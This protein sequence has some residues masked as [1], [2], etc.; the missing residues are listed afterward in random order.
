MTAAPAGTN[1]TPG[2]DAFRFNAAF[3]R[4]IGWLTDWEQQALRNKRVA[5]AG[6]GGVGGFHLLT[7]AR[8]GIGAFNIADLDHFEIANFNRQIGATMD[9]LGRPKA[10]TLGEMA[11]AIN[12]EL[13]IKRFDTGIDV[14]N[15]DAFLDGVDLFVDGFDFFVLDIRRKVFARC[16]E[17]GIPALTAAPIG[18][19]VGFLAFTKDGMTFEDYFRLEGQ[20][21]LRQYV[22]FFLGVAPSGIHLSYLADPSRLDIKGKKG[23]STVVGCELCAAVTAA[24]A[25]KLLI[26][27][28]EVK[29]A[30]YHHH[31]DAYLG[32]TV[33]TCLPQGNAT[34]E[35]L[36]K[37][38]K[39]ELLFRGMPESPERKY[40][41]SVIEEI[42]DCARWAPSGDNAQPWRF[43]ITGE[44]TL[45]VHIANE[46]G[47]NV[48]EYRDGE[49]TIIS[50]GIL[51]ETLRIAA[52]GFQRRMDWRYR[53]RDGS[54]YRIEARF[55]P[56]NTIEPDP[57]GGYLS[58]RS[59]NR[60]PYHLR[61]LR[62]TDKQALEAALGNRLTIDWHESAGARWRIARLVGKATDIRLRIPEAFAVHQ[63]I[64]DWNGNLSPTGIPAGAIG[65]DD[66]TLRIMKWAMQAWSRTKRLNRFA[67]T[68][69]AVLQ[70]DYLPGLCSA[71]YFTIRMN[72]KEA[73]PDERVQA[74]LET[75]QAIQRF[76]LTATKLGLAMQPCLATLAFAHY[77]RSGT[78]FTRE[79]GPLRAAGK[80]AAS[81]DNILAGN[82]EFVFM[83]RLG[84]PR[85]RK[86][87]CRSTR[88]SFD[89][90]IRAS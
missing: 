53:G 50:A 47:G 51:L 73:S 28:G 39:A 21:Q 40:P 23:P 52:S 75:G 49:P 37:L 82:G 89:Q 44:D 59:V 76:W 25:V 33:V 46:S 13:R 60:W 11:L 86:K 45:I 3:D 83:G 77:G 7:L 58:L 61:P 29:P 87:L 24:A 1:T 35:Q 90:L 78:P 42:I 19:G 41:S 36:K 84:W 9:T 26:G 6:M 54:I 31:F 43:Q 65:L 69:G 72:A 81:V 64:I 14:Q 74:L 66:M 55:S 2:D 15:M 16:A 62:K 27:R 20:S 18:M 4:N 10:E 17:L 79:A 56:D 30:P 88:R 80:L 32:Q 8:L 63:R 71:A 22:N 38:E 34:P 5:I 48:Y 67:G 68:G 57:L 85:P 70:M 12:P